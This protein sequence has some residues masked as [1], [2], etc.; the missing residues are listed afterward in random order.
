MEEWGPGIVGLENLR[1]GDTSGTSFSRARRAVGLF[2]AKGL[3]D[4]KVFVWIVE[5]ERS[6]FHPHSGCIIATIFLLLRASPES[7]ETPSAW[8][9]LPSSKACEPCRGNWMSKSHLCRLTHQTTPCRNSSACVHLVDCERG[10]A[11]IGSPVCLLKQ[12]CLPQQLPQ[13]SALFEQLLASSPA[14]LGGRTQTG[15][16]RRSGRGIVSCASWV[17]PS[18]VFV[19]GP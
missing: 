19:Q 9:S 6:R 2:E 17:R 10:H 3:Y 18:A 16:F 1:C 12:I 13:F 15:L 8:H 11:M 4:S 5:A 7:G 14:L